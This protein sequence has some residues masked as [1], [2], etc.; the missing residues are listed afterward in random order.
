MTS[1][2]NWSWSLILSNTQSMID[3][4][5]P[6]VALNMIVPWHSPGVLDQSLRCCKIIRPSCANKS[7]VQKVCFRCLQKI[8]C[9]KDSHLLSDVNYLS[10]LKSV[11]FKPCRRLKW[12]VPIIENDHNFE[13]TEDRATVFLKWTDFKKQNFPRK[14][15]IT[16]SF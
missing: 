12:M 5:W 15:Y 4:T 13:R 7:C 3:P 6:K 11:H 2:L 1:K 9:W 8:L 16:S 14:S 10:L